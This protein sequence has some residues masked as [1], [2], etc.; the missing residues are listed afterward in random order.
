MLII[1]FKFKQLDVENVEIRTN[2][3]GGLD[4]II[5][6]DGKRE[7]LVYAEHYRIVECNDDDFCEEDYCLYNPSH[8]LI[9]VGYKRWLNGI[10]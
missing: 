2:P 6:K 8:I 9:P 1:C 5:L 10:V 7:I 4:Y 3:Y